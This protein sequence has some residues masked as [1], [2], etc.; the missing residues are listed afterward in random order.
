MKTSYA[1]YRSE[2]DDLV[3]QELIEKIKNDKKYLL[4]LK[5]LQE[6]L[7]ECEQSRLSLI[8]KKTE[9]ENLS[10][11]KRLRTSRPISP[12]NP[13]YTS[14]Y[15]TDFC[16]DCNLFDF[17]I[18]FENLTR[19]G[20]IETVKFYSCNSDGSEKYIWNTVVLTESGKRFLSNKYE[21]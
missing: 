18:R 3:A 1:S 12:N 11:I 14:Y 6:K 13:D 16:K 5:I 19:S 2:L 7:K 21:N 8:N 15:E 17:D 4:M 20:L 9:H 10:F